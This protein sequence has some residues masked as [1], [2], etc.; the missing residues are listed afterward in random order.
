MMVIYST[1]C[2]KICIKAIFLSICFSEFFKQFSDGESKKGDISQMLSVAQQ[3][4][5][6]GQGK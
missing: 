6:L 1:L 5:K 2:V 3:I 4:N